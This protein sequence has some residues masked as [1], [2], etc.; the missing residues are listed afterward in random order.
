MTPFGT[1]QPATP[2]GTSQP[3]TPLGPSQPVES[4]NETDDEIIPETQPT[5]P[6]KGKRKG[7]QREKG[8]GRGK[9]LEGAPRPWSDVEEE[10]LAKAY[11][12][13][14]TRANIGKLFKFIDI[15]FFSKYKCLCYYF[16]FPKYI[17]LCYYFFFRNIY[18]YV[19]YC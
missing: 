10:A 18:V 7:K 6:T 5:P 8:P 9:P 11:V 12:F 17:C 15:Y 2:L 3:A 1:S 19:L 14:S 4:E 16:F 13:A